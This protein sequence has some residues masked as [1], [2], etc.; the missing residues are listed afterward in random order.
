MRLRFAATDAPLGTKFTSG[1]GNAFWT[2][3]APTNPA[4]TD[5]SDQEGTSKLWLKV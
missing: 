5:V 1:E 4:G 3:A 2:V